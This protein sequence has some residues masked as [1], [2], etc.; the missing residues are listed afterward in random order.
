MTHHAVLRKIAKKYYFKLFSPTC[1]P[2]R[3]RFRNIF[4]FCY[5]HGENC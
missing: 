2:N 4:W 5:I 3:E 1:V